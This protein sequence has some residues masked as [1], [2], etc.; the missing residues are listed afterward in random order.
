[1]LQRFVQAMYKWKGCV[2]SSTF[3]AQDTSFFT[4]PFQAHMT[5]PYQAKKLQEAQPCSFVNLTL[6]AHFKGDV[7]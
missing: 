4:S 7:L 5:P 2:L 1:M 6:T 3:L